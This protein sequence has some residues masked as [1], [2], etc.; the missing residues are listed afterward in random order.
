MAIWNMVI[1]LARTPADAAS[2]LEAVLELVR[3]ASH[4]APGTMLRS[5]VDTIHRTAGFAT[6]V[7]HVYR[8]ECDD[9]EVSLVVG[10]PDARGAVIGDRTPRSNV[11]QRADDRLVVALTGSDGTPLAFVSMDDPASGQRPDDADLRLVHAICSHAGQALDHARRVQRAAENERMLSLLIAVSPTLTSCATAEELFATV[12]E[13]VVPHL[14]F[15]RMAAYAAGNGTAMH[16]RHT[17]GWD[18]ERMLAGA[19][20]VARIEALLSPERERGG[21]WLLGADELFGRRA[22]RSG[23]RSARN[24]EGPFAWADDCLIVPWR[25]GGG[26]LDGLVVIEDPVDRLRPGDDRSRA[27]RLLVDLASAAQDGIEHRARLDHLASHDPLTG[28]RNRRGLEE[29]LAAHPDVAVMICD[30]DHFKQINDRH[31]HAVGDRVLARF[32]EL[33]RELARDSDVP[34]RLGG[35]EFCVVLPGSD[36]AGAIAAAERLRVAVAAQ[37]GELV[38]EG[39][40]VSIGVATAPGAHGDARSLLA[41][42]DRRLYRAKRTG[43]DRTVAG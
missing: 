27:V 31:G 35:E 11:D 21:C 1:D 42:A 9:Y 2:P 22:R 29:L 16:L 33:L 23:P 34:F 32:G 10:S 25:T 24:G 26:A 17:R 13:T 5:V 30:L 4:D 19:M 37:L 28:V 39:V 40:T 12:G 18:S 41:A 14:G 8:P 3:T 43:R 15:E 36:R 6:V 20:S 7:L 38:P